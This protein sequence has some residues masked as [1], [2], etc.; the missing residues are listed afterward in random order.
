MGLP[1]YPLFWVKKE[2]KW[3]EEKPAGKQKKKKKTALPPA[4]VSSRSGSAT[5]IT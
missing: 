5:D 3:K 1:L 2:K 4:P